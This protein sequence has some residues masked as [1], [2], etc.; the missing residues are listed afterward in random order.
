MRPRVPALIAALLFLAALPAAAGAAGGRADLR[1]NHERVLAYWTAERIASAKPRDYVMTP[2]GQLVPAAKPP[3]TPGG[4][5]GGGGGGGG[6][7]STVTGASWTGDGAIETRSGRVL[8]SDADGDWICSAAAISD[9]STTDSYSLVVSAGHC[10]YDGRGGWASNW[11]YIPQFDDAP[12]YSCDDTIHGC[13][14]ARALALSSAFV[15]GGGFGNNTVQYD[16]AIAVVGPGGHSGTDQLDALGAYD[17]RTSGNQVGQEAWAF[18]YPAAQKYKGR[19]LTYC[20]GTTVEDPYGAPTWGLA[21]DMTGGSS[22][23][24]WLVETTDPATDSGRIASVNSYGYSGLK[25]MFGPIF[26]S[27]TQAVWDAANAATP[28]AD[29]IDHIT[30]P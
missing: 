13:W 18:G 11:M 7:G 12:T 21:C 28:D 24:P 10:A 16:W 23:G 17:L 15:T 19:D 3:G 20:R 26:N 27:N 1:S 9:G 30:V 2:S 6:D 14:T 29:G 25:Y 5:P 22:G 8:F 4:G